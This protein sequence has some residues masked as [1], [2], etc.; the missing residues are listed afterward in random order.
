[1]FYE[2]GGTEFI[3]ETLKEYLAM[4]LNWDPEM[5]EEE[6]IGHIKEYLYL[7][8]GDGYEELYQYII[9]QDEAGNGAGCFINNW[10]RP[11]QM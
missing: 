11:R 1:M 2:G 6:F 10:D 7:Y 4:R 5:T 8:Y 9:M 3:F